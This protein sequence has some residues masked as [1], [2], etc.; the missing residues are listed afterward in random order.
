MSYNKNDVLKLED[1]LLDCVMDGFDINDSE[2]TNSKA[3][4]LVNNL[5]FL[6]KTLE[7]PEINNTYKA[8]LKQF[9]EN[10]SQAYTDVIK[11][12]IEYA[13]KNQKLLKINFDLMER[14]QNIAGVNIE[15]ANKF[16]ENLAATIA[17]EVQKKYENTTISS[18]NE[19]ISE[20][21]EIESSSEFS[22]TNDSR[23]VSRNSSDSSQ[24]P[25]K[26][27]GILKRMLDTIVEVFKPNTK[28]NENEQSKGQKSKSPSSLIKMM[29][30]GIMGTKRTRDDFDTTQIERSSKRSKP[31]V[32]QP[33]PNTSHSLN[34]SDSPQSETP[35]IRH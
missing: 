20:A 2:T 12:Y 14:A 27:V 28:L 26:K 31:S 21:S 15:K 5:A 18:L 23:S 17:Q 8:Q 25:G 7:N 9:Y 30:G 16:K 1:D 10:I 34:S 33:T 19:P 4:K 29:K 13:D 6:S 35:R 22:S 32:E 24:N 3:K 11:Q